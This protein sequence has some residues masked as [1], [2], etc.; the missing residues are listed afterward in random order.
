MTGI[1]CALAGSGGSIYVG[2]TTVTVGSYTDPGSFT[3]YGYV[4]FLAGNATP[5]KWAGT[6]GNFVQLCWY[7][8]GVDFVA[9]AVEGVFPN[10]GWTTMTVGGVPFTRTSGNYSTNGTSTTWT[11][12]TASNPYGTTIGATRAITW[13]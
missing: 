11:W 12:L 10:E 6:G 7:D 1:T 5:T 3:I 8:S 13:S 4:D 2:S 9:F